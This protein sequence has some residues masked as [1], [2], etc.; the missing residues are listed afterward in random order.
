ML[1]TLLGPLPATSIDEVVAKMTAIDGALSDADGLK[2]FNRLYL[3]VTRG[4]RAE[5]AGRTA[6]RDPAFVD[7]LDVIFANLYF[8]AAIAGD[9]SPAASPPAWRPLFAARHRALTPLQFALAGMNAHINRDLPLGIVM[10]FHELG[11]A[12]TDTDARHADFEQVNEVLERVEQT[13]K[14]DF[15]TGVIGAIDVAAG[16][17]DD[18][19]AMW[20][21]RVAREAAWTNAEVLWALRA[22]PLLRDRY[23]ARLD[24]LT[25]LAGRGL[26]VPAS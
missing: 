12:P 25:G 16:S 15:A 7:R 8:D 5:L 11:G 21:V 23:F 26:L 3:N 18:L 14:A 6:F 17:A 9:A 4:V 1:D 24:G 20:K 10:A 13:I 2:W 19:V 22:Q